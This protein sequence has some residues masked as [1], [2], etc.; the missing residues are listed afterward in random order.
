LT[1]DVLF[2]FAVDILSKWP[3]WWYHCTTAYCTTV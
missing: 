1:F 2:I 3:L